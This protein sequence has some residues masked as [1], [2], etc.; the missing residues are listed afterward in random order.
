MTCY[1]MIS[2][3]ID[4]ILKIYLSMSYNYFTKRLI[5][6]NHNRSAN[7]CRAYIRSLYDSI[8]SKLRIQL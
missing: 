2:S 1:D 5:Y 4:Q 6:D 7:Q 3:K 8:L